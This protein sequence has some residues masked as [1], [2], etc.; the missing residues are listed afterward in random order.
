MCSFFIELVDISKSVG[1]D[2]LSY[3][4]LLKDEHP[5]PTQVTTRANQLQK[6]IEEL[7]KRADV[8]YQQQCNVH[9]LNIGTC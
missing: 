1:R 6:T 4:A 3:L 7:N 9:S 2:C 5:D 8:S